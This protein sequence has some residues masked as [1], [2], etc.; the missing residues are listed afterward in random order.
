MES[1][2]LAGRLSATRGSQLLGIVTMLDKAM[3]NT[4]LILLLEVAGKRLLFPGDAQI[5]N[6]SYALGKP[7]VVELLS[8]V[9][10]LKVGHHG[11]PQCNTEIA[12]QG[13]QSWESEDSESDD[14]SPI[15]TGPQA[16]IC[17]EEAEVPRDCWLPMKSN[18]NFHSTEELPSGELF[19]GA[20]RLLTYLGR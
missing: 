5:E 19:D 4:S 2:W 9:D 6:W 15:H 13:V 1:R 20:H 12:T 11:G 14:V 7:E 17:G 10:L 3:N 8:G 18:T 16:W